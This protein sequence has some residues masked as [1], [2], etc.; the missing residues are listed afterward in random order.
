LPDIGDESD[1]EHC[2]TISTDSIWT[3][4]FKQISKN[5]PI[6]EPGTPASDPLAVSANKNE[7]K[8]LKTLLRFGLVVEKAPIGESSLASRRPSSLQRPFSTATNSKTQRTASPVA[9][10]LLSQKK[11]IS[12]SFFILDPTP[13]LQHQ[14]AEQKPIA[15]SPYC[16]A[17]QYQHFH[18]LDQSKSSCFPAA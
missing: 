7:Q 18:F 8:T 3:Q 14:A 2:Y 16:E 10:D 17:T 4:K 9:V 12:A 5:H 1:K 15:P 6:K 13:T 11:T